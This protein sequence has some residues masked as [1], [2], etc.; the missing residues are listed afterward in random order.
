MKYL[1]QLLRAILA[2]FLL[3]SCQPNTGILK[4]TAGID[5]VVERKVDSLLQLMTLAEKVGQMNQYNGSWDITGP[6]PSGGDNELKYTHIKNGLVG[7]MLNIVSSVA[8]RKAQEL[9][10]NESRLGIPLLFGYD[11]VH[12]Y[13]TMFPIP[14]GEAASWDLEAIEKSA[15]IAAIESAA[16]G[17]HWTF[18]PMVDITR[19]A[20]WGRVMEG[21]GEDPYLG[22]LIAAARVRGFQGDDLSAKNTIAACAKHFAAYG[23]AEGGK[24]YNTVEIN[25]HTLEN[26]VFPPFKAAVEAGVATVMNSFNEIGGQ[27]VTSNAHLQREIL[28]ERWGFNGLIVSDWG[29]IREL[30]NHG[31]A[32]DAKEAAALAAK[33]GCDMDMESLAY[34]KELVGLV[35]AGTV[36]EAMIDDAVRRILRLKFKLGLFDDP[37]RYCN[38]AA[39]KQDLMRAEHLEAAREIGRKSIVLLKN[40]D[41]LLPLPKDIGTIAVIGPFANDRDTPLGSWRAKAITNSAVSLLEGLKETVGPGTK[42]LYAEGCKVAIGD[43]TFTNELIINQTDKSGFP[44]A[45][46]AARQADV[47]LLAIGEDCWQTGEGRSQMDI[48]L[49]G[50]QE[51]L[52]QAIYK[53]NQKVVVILMNGRPMTINW[54]ADNVPAIVEAWHLGHMAGLSIADVIWGDYNP[55][56]KLP[57]SF[58]YEVG[59]CPLYYNHKSTGRPSTAP[60]M[61]FYAHYTDGPNEARYPFGYGLSYTTFSYSAPTL[62]ST[63]MTMDGSLDVSVEVTNTGERAGEEVVQLYIQDLVGSVTRPVKALKGFKKIMLAPGASETVSF[64]I[65]AKDLAFFTAARK[66]AAEAGDFK[67]FVGTNSNNVQEASFVLE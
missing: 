27:P 31:V 3:T 63:S 44:K 56:G 37:F 12:G 32:K 62:S 1:K 23:F 24:D 17:I 6:V 8:T 34:V 49:A 51:E 58:P 19:D 39:E 13:K 10:V 45:I 14:L 28:K 59:Q 38:P 18:A 21:A 41:N 52:L 60:G 48:G 43:R 4:D 65:S 11:V 2:V 66:W 54:A 30:V 67:V 50:V 40:Q 5:P 7:S 53:V 15:R 16:A 46:E 35:E 61:V 33:S 22:S 29:T 55:A 57:M 47:V 26:V 36:P 9:A 42:L 64:K 25:E 20:R